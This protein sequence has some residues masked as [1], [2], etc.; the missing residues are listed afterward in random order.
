MFNVRTRRQNSQHSTDAKHGVFFFILLIVNISLSLDFDA[1]R[2]SE[3]K[4]HDD[5]LLLQFHGTE[6]IHHSV[7]NN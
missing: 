5:F 6:H 7:S 2:V 4:L 3:L 1:L